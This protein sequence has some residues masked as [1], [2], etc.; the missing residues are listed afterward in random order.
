MTE[1]PTTEKISLKSERKDNANLLSPHSPEGIAELKKYVA[2]TL[3]LNHDLNNPLAGVM[4]FL[5]LALVHKDKMEPKAY[6]LL[7]LIEKSAVKLNEC[8]IEFTE[9]KHKMRSKVDLSS[10]EQSK[11]ES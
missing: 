11:T 6:E 1:N 7:K 9:E 10:L 3:S 2:A 4:G 8:L 5:E